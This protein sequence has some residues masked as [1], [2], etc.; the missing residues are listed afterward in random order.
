MVVNPYDTDELAHA[1]HTALT[2][3]AEERRTRMLRMRAVVEENNVYRWAGNLIGEL[4]DIRP[5]GSLR[6]A[7]WADNAE[8]PS[9]RGTAARG[10]GARLRRKIT[11]GPR[12]A[13]GRKKT[14]PSWKRPH[15]PR[16]GSGGQRT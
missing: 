14:E 3:P 5:E 13:T 7:R 1:I 16:D 11:E 8:A 9:G 15:A 10:P 12:A 2:M 6:S 4:A